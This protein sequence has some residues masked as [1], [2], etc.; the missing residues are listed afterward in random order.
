MQESKNE[1]IFALMGAICFT[2]H[3]VYSVINSFSQNEYQAITWE[4][5]VWWVIFI[6]L[7]I[8]LFVRKKNI[9]FLISPAL[10]VIMEAIYLIHYFSIENLLY[11]IVYI[12][13]F[14]LLLI[15]VIPSIKNKASATKFLCFIPAGL[16]FAMHLYEWIR[17]GFFE[18]LD[19]FWK[20]I[21]FTLVDTAGYMFLGLWLKATISIPEVTVKMNPYATPPQSTIPQVQQVVGGADT[22]KIYKELLDFGAITQEEFDAKKK[23]ILGL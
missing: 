14:V 15:N 11:I 3:V 1:K 21:L 2:I 10:A 18:A 12:M 13:L 6:L 23:Q 20:Y 4:T 17:Y 22:L 9:A 8:L 7:A 19:V 16:F 5:I